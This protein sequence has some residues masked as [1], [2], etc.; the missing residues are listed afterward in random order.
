MLLGENARD[1]AGMAFSRPVRNF[2]SN[3]A[4]TQIRR[5]CSIGVVFRFP[6]LVFNLLIAVCLYPYFKIKCF[7]CGRGKRYG[8]NINEFCVSVQRPKEILERIVGAA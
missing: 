6:L 4:R 5:I 8:L 1:T 7:V 3:G 2:I